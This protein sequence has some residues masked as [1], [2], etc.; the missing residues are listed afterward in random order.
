MP[1][2]LASQLFCPA[3]SCSI[4]DEW[5]DVAAPAEHEGVG[6]MDQR[7]QIDI[8]HAIGD[9]LDEAPVDRCDTPPSSRRPACG[10]HGSRRRPPDESVSRPA[11]V[12]TRISQV[13][14][15][16]WRQSN[17]AWIGTPVSSEKVRSAAIGAARLRGND[18]SGPGQKERPRQDAGHDRERVDAG[19]EHA[20]VRPAPRSRP[21]A[22]CQTLTSSFHSTTTDLISRSARKTRAGSTAGAKRECQ[23]ANSVRPVCRAAAIS[24]SSS[25]TV[26]PGG[27][28]SST[29]LP[30]FNAA[31]ACA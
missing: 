28:S 21:G 10:R 16:V 25:L 4:L 19:I 22:G 9:Q 31:A 3:A 11:S 29:C 20:E 7:R 13:C 15:P 2:N 8:G 1:E 6:N 14:G 27:F 23:V 26:A 5:F 24:G 30:A 12:S 17:S 18:S